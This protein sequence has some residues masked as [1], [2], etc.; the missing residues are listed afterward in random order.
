[1]HMGE[2]YPHE[3]RLV[4]LD[5]AVHEIRRSRRNVVVN[6]FHA[7]SRQRS[8]IF[9]TAIG[10]GMN[11][12]SRPEAPAEGRV[13]RIVRLLGIFLGVQVIEIA[14]ELVEAVIRRRNSSLSPR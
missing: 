3:K 12:A 8:R 4:G 7:L 2:A 6:R 5:L 11:N 10:E 1:M 9:D 13:F 14:V